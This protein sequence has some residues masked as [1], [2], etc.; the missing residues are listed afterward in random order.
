MK[1]M[2]GH[3]ARDLAVVARQV[4]AQLARLDARVVLAES[5]TAGLV[6]ASLGRIAG[7]SQWLCGSAVVYRI[8]TK[9][10]WLGVS[11]RDVGKYTAVSDV[12][13]RQMA[14]GVMRKTPEA[15]WSAS[16]TGHLGPEA[17]AD[18]DGV[19]FVGVARRT[20]RSIHVIDSCRMVL[21]ASTRVTRQRQAAACALHLLLKSL[22]AGAA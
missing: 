6:S 8:D 22:R 17:P 7:I 15:A 13:A 2:P 12:V 1:G 18:Q 11:A 5:C 3:T 14:V 9:L 16:V 4:A 20:G 21:T 10:S 19:I